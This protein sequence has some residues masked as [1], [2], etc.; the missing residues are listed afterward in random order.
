MVADAGLL[1]FCIREDLERRA[2]RRMAVLHPLKIVLTN[3]TEADAFEVELPNH[4]EDPSRG[5]RRIPFAKEI[6]VE[7]EDFQEV[8]PKKWFRLAPGAEVRLRGACL[9]TCQEIIK[10]A[11][12]QVVELRCTWDPA[13]RGGNAPDGR[14]VKGTLHWV[15]AAQALQAEVRL[16]EPL[17]TQEDPMAVPEGLDWKTF[18]NPGSLQVLTHAW[19][20]P[21]LQG[22]RPGEGFQ[23]ERT[24]Y[25]AVDTDSRPGKLV[26]NRTVGLRDSW[27]KIEA[28]G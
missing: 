17:F 12:G 9:I 16:Y 20:E 10:D 23:F 4:P 11:S 18:L 15:S 7:Q 1:E 19:V 2:S 25:F 28:K 6:F 13:S 27:A 14:K 5:N 24:G 21:G 22:A 8:P 3:F 26:F